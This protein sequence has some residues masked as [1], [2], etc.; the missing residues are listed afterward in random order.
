MFTPGKL[1]KKF[2][3][4]VRRAG[5]NS[6]NKGIQPAQSTRCSPV[7]TRAVGSLELEL[8]EERGNRARLEQDCQKAKAEA[9][10]LA[11]AKAKSEDALKKEV[12]DKDAI[13]QR[14]ER[15]ANEMQKKVS[16]A[17]KGTRPNS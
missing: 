2:W 12:G 9:D 13:I 7:P 8:T 10:E 6:G 16:H 1:L 3:R 5:R 17:G 4:H 14:L 15:E 11:E